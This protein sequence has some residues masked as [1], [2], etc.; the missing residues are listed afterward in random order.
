MFR[1]SRFPSSK[2][3]DGADGP[4]PFEN[5]A[6]MG[7]GAT[8]NPLSDP[9]VTFSQ[10]GALERKSGKGAEKSLLSEKVTFPPLGHPKS[11]NIPLATA[12]SRHRG[13]QKLH[14]HQIHGDS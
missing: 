8:Q 4:R 1:E 11:I 5:K 3:T 2:I 7:G 13:A 10:K 6:Q 14:F 9:K 12:P